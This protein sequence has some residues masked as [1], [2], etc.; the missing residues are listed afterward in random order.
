VAVEEEE[1]E[2]ALAGTWSW[3]WIQVLV[4]VVRGVVL[5]LLTQAALLS[6]RAAASACHG[7]SSALRVPA[8]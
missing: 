3:C 2:R 6:I 8:V 4:L 7:S 1:E 5:V